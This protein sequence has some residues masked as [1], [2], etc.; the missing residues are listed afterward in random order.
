[1]YSPLVNP[2]IINQPGE[3][4]ARDKITAD[5]KIQATLY[6]SFENSKDICTIMCLQRTTRP[7][8]EPF[9]NVS[10]SSLLL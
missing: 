2:N 6:N 1:M 7:D 10:T 8:I 9:I 4:S 5:A 3:E